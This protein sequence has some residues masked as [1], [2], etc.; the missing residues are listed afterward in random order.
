[1]Y[2]P[3]PT[4]SEAPDD[5]NDRDVRYRLVS[6]FAPGGVWARRNDPRTF[7]EFGSAQRRSSSPHVSHCGTLRCWCR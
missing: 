3:S 4:V 1:V 7:A 6:F 5:P 2:Y